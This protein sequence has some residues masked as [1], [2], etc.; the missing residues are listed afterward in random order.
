MSIFTKKKTLIFVKL[1]P[2][3][4]HNNAKR[5]L[6]V[7]ELNNLNY[8]VIRPVDSNRRGPQKGGK[9]YHDNNNNR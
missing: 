6:K 2:P 4:L 5:K 3:Q 1:I 9:H 8:K 7:V